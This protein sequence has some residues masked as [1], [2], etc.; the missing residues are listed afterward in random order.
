MGNFK[1][2]FELT[3]SEILSDLM[4]QRSLVCNNKAPCNKNNLAELRSAF[5]VVIKR[6]YVLGKHAAFG[7]TRAPLWVLNL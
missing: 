6:G 2:A 4:K 3:M 5:A 7:G 1:I